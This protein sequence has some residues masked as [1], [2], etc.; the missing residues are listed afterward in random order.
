MNSQERIVF[1]QE[2]FNARELFYQQVPLMQPYTYEG[3]MQN[4]FTRENL[5]M[6]NLIN[7]KRILRQ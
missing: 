6:M 5:A 4:V 3:A 1:S 7:G 2:A